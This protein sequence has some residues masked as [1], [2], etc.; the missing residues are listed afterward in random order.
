VSEHDEVLE[1]QGGPTRGA[2]GV[3]TATDDRLNDRLEPMPPPSKR[4]PR[5]LLLTVV[6]VVAS[7]AI[8]A[9]LFVYV[10]NDINPGGRPGADVTVII[11]SHSSTKQIAALLSSKH[12]IR[13]SRVFAYWT[14]IEGKGPYLAGEY[15]LK[16][17]SKYDDVATALAAGPSQTQDRFVVPEGLTLRQIADRVGR[18]PGRNA[19]TF[20]RLATSG[21]VRSPVEPAEVKTLEGLV[22]PSTYFVGPKDL[23]PQILQRMIDGFDQMAQ[24]VNLTPGASLLH[25]TPYQVVI[26]AS[27]IEREAKFDADRAKIA[28]VIYNRLA[29]GMPLGFNST[30]AYGLNKTAL[31]TGDIKI[32]GPYNTYL[33]KG[34]PPTPIASPGESS[35]QAAVTP[36]VGPLLYFAAVDKA[37]HLAFAATIAEHNKNVAL[38]RANGVAP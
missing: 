30:V 1:D 26:V 29:K 10:K 18:L 37:G 32:P 17:N 2:G 22:F 20:Y 25:L 16:R 9:G 34:L 24:K 6:V 7:V 21:V 15:T 12:V 14:K 35:L 3:T 19:D 33:D 31:D 27:M 13:G 36:E 5:W 4:R 28:E 8:L 23:E 11:P 38:S